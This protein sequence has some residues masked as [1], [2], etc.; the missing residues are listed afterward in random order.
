MD[1]LQRIAELHCCFYASGY[2][3]RSGLR[4]DRCMRRGK[5]RPCM[6][7]LRGVVPKLLT[8]AAREAATVEFFRQFGK[9]KKAR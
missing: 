8:A 1:D 2:C 6:Y 9:K 7:F 3:W 5:K 4:N